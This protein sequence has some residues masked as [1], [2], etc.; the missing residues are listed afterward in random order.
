MF[1]KIDYLRA[2]SVG[3]HLLAFVDAAS[4]GGSIR[5]KSGMSSV[6]WKQLAGEKEELLA[7]IK[8][9]LSIDF[10]SIHDRWHDSSSYS[11]FKVGFLS[12]SQ[13]A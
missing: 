12:P 10:L 7:N 8:F 11:V 4:R 1:T 6:T 5:E 2:E 13:C 9:L 3:L